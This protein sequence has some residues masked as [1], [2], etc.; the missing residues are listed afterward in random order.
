MKANKIEFLLEMIFRTYPDKLIGGRILPTKMVPVVFKAY[1][2]SE[3]DFNLTELMRNYHW[4]QHHDTG[5]T[6]DEFYRGSILWKMRKED[7]KG[8]E[9]FLRRIDIRQYV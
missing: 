3:K 2:I 5:I 9:T 6:A 8:I 7:W 1:G 4:V